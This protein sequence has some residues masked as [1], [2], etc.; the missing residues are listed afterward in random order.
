MAQFPNEHRLHTRGS[1]D[2]HGSHVL[3]III[4]LTV[5]TDQGTRLIME[6]EAEAARKA[7]LERLEG[8]CA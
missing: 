6:A 4:V 2:S 1:F 8:R 7:E 3:L 5:S